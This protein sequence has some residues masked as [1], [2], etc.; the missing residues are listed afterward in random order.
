MQKILLVLPLVT[1]LAAC[2]GTQGYQGNSQNRSAATGAVAGAVL[3]AAVSKD[4]DRIKGAALGAA[5]GGVAGALIGQAN[6]PGQCR[7]R[8][9]YGR[10]YIAPC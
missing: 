10:E 3:G 6:Q 8:D 9:A 5:A 7:Y 2:Q 1:G 4:G